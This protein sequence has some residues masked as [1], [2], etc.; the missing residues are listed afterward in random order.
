[1]KKIK[2]VFIAAMFAMLT[3]CATT[4]GTTG[5]QA[6]NAESGD[7]GVIRQKTEFKDLPVEMQEAIL[8]GG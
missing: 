8:N 2:Y 7:D 3:G 4:A 6:V 1:M 5:F